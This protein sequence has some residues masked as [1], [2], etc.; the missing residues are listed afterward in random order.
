MIEIA[1]LLN[2]DADLTRLQAELVTCLAQSGMPLPEDEHILSFVAES[3]RFGRARAA[4]AVEGGEACGVIAWRVEGDAGF[5]FLFCVLAAASPAAAAQLL[6]EALRDLPAARV[7]RGIYAELPAVS[8]AIRAALEGAGFVGVARTLMQ[9]DLRRQAA[10]HS[11]LPAGYALNAWDDDWLEAAADVIYQANIGTL[12]AMIIPEMQSL[13]STRRIVFHVLQGRYGLFDPAASGVICAGD[14]VVGVTLVTRRHT[15]PGFT[16]EIC[17]LE[18][19]RRR[20]LARSLMLHTHAA[21]QG[22]GVAW[23]TLGVTAGNPARRL[24]ESL[25]YMP[26]GTLWAFVRPRPAR[27]PA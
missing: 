25:G 16:A 17:V 8:A 12:D 2:T 13:P 3:V 21:L 14:A 4:L 6:Q 22:D 7:P 5:V 18:A 1:S 19:H 27:W 26:I 15:G 11:A 10:S 20:G 23:N 9:Y 24:Y